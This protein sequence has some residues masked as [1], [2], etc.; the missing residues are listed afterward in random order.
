MMYLWGFIVFGCLAWYSLVS[1]YIAIYGALDIKTMLAHLR[2]N[3]GED[4]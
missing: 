3:G 4:R 2:Q 1:I